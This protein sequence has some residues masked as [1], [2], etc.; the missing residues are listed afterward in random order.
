MYACNSLKVIS[1]LFKQTDTHTIYTSVK[2]LDSMNGDV[3]MHHAKNV[4]WEQKV[5][6]AKLYMWH[7]YEYFF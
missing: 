7:S 2:S 3:W 5:V 4:Q 1:E 6:S